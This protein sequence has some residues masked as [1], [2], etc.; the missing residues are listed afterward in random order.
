MYQQ[1]MVDYTILK[2]PLGVQQQMTVS[3]IYRLTLGSFMSSVLCQLR[4]IPKGISG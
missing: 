1:R 3:H 2:D 4:E